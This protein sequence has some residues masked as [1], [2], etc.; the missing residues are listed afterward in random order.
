MEATPSDST[1]SVTAKRMKAHAW[2]F[3][4][5]GGACLIAE[6]F[7]VPTTTNQNIVYSVL[8]MVAVASILIG[9]RVHHPRERLGW[10]C[11]ALAMT[12][13]TLGDGLT[14]YYQVVNHNLPFP[15]LAD[16]L[17]LAGYPFLF[18]GI[19]RTT[20]STR[21][22]SRREDTADA[23]IIAL[24]A[25]AISWHFL[26]NA[27]AHD[28]TLTTFEMLVNLAYPMMD[29][30]LIFVMF[31]ALLF[32]R[33]K[34]I[35]QKLLA[36]SLIIM[37]AADFTYDLLVLH[38]S[39]S[40]GNFV[41][42]FY[43]LQYV[44][45][46]AAALH[47]SVSLANTELDASIR[48]GTYREN[49]QLQRMPVVIVAAFIPP[50]IL[51]VSTALGVPVNVVA[52]SSL[53]VA[54]SLVIFLRLYWLI[55]RMTN[56]TLTLNAN[57]QQLEE[58]EQRFRLA[59]EDNM[60]PMLFTDLNDQTIAVNDAFCGMIGYPREELLGR[61]SALFT[62]PD[63]I[64]IAEAAHQRVALGEVTQVRYTKRYLRK[65]GRL[66]FVDVLR[67][68][69]CDADGNALYN[70]ISER[71]ITE[72]RALTEQLSHQA[73]HDSLTGL[74]NRALFDYELDQARS[75]ITREDG[76]Y[77][78]LLMDLDDFKG[79]NDSLGHAAGDQILVEVTRRLEQVTRTSD[80]LCRFGGD[81]F[82]YLAEGLGSPSDAELAA[83][84]LLNALAEPFTVLGNRVE[85]HASIGIVIADSSDVDRS[86]VIMNA[87]IALY[88]AKRLGKNNY[89]LFTRSML[90]QASS[91]FTLVQEL[92]G[93]LQ[94]GELVM[95]YQ[96]IIDLAS[97]D[98]VGFEALMRWQHPQRGWIPPG[99]F[100]PIA[101]QSN[102]ILELG[103][104]ALEQSIAVASSWISPSP[105][106]S[107]PFVTVNVSARQVHD[108]GFVSLIETLL[109]ENG[110]AHERLIIEITE[111]AALHNVADTMSVIEQLS[112]LGIR[113]AL[114]DFGT[115][116]SSL[117][118]LARL[119]PT[120]IKI[121]QSF[122]S[123]SRS[124]TRDDALLEAIIGLAH[125]LGMTL[126]AEGIETAEQF[127]RLR[128]LGSEFGQGFYFS[129]AVPSS[130]ALSLLERFNGV[131]SSTLE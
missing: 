107:R 7:I 113:L 39:Y 49:S 95:H 128:D 83:S 123:P 11:L 19:M 78:V 102:L 30:A 99:V 108:P 63:D 119:R 59:F 34:Y 71:D 35:F 31:R 13:F 29:I 24:G 86:T 62:Y 56:Q 120:I 41:D 45:M 115:G 20:R 17:Y 77:A 91:R 79:V 66:I 50:T 104:L 101:E 1:E 72:E 8:G 6:Y 89:V 68:L 109:D 22:V 116:Y 117:S 80:T 4:S 23:A 81:E 3:V 105:D 28:V 61:A 106:S 88:E 127:H 110:L 125:R 92:C 15:S 84:R 38:N 111:S 122:V 65:D 114:D 27:Y 126:I 60:A 2:K 103:R 100:I 40:D 85:Q 33:E 94:A 73:L 51:I 112:C 9:V 74:A 18:V 12:C 121:D 43:L 44:V 25:L 16:A 58:L 87:D 118:Y 82:L 67:S 53:S 70:V 124:D 57:L 96:P 47:P 131:Q 32:R 37:F 26:M 36:S 97:S 90:Q 93:A 42:G 130:E 21:S 129:P 10:Y 64:G 75:R 14:T 5:I 69:A 55:N 98:V 52:L 76:Y 48:H 46:G 54:V